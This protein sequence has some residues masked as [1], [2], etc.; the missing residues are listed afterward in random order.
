MIEYF[1]GFAWL[2]IAGHLAQS[3][4]GEEVGES[5][6]Q[7]WWS[8]KRTK[9]TLGPTMVIDKRVTRLKKN[10]SAF[11]KDFSEPSFYISLGIID[12]IYIQYRP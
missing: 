5:S 9:R 2:P 3:N 7:W 8:S 1:R 11:D 12:T 4:Q 6:I 10:G